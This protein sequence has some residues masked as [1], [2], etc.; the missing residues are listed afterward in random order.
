[1]GCLSLFRALVFEKLRREEGEGSGSHSFIPYFTAHNL[2]ETGWDGW[3]ISCF[4]DNVYFILL[5]R[6]EQLILIVWRE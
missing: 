2:G 3:T 5:E 4:H 6:Y 1:L